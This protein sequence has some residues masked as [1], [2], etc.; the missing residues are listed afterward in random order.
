MKFLNVN[1]L[2]SP[3][4]C[5]RSKNSFL[6]W[7][8][9]VRGSNVLGSKVPFWL[10]VQR[11]GVQ[12][13]RVQKSGVQKFI[14]NLGFKSPGFKC[15]GFK[16]SFGT[17]GSKVQGSKVW[18]LKSKVQKSRVLKF[19]LALGVQRSGFKRQSSIV[20]GSNVPKSVLYSILSN[21]Y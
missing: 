17:W 14:F 4:N 5:L 1:I 11:S 13:S 21:K 19:L 2:N 16:S 7:D 9:K 18:V 10:G 15:L 8:S 20:R 3:S 12:K 6:P